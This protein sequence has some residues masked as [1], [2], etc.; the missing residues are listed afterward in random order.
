MATPILTTLEKEIENKITYLAKNEYLSIEKEIECQLPRHYEI[1]R[2]SSSQ[3]KL[4]GIY[5]NFL[6][7]VISSIVCLS[8]TRLTSWS[9]LEQQ[10]QFAV[11]H[12]TVP[13]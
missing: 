6:T 4:R 13:S 11:S 3:S 7:V 9:F 2:A 5:S 1:I 10:R 12:S 8:V